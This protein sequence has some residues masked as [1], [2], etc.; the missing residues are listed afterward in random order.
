MSS[1]TLYLA[2]MD[3]EAGGLQGP[4]QEMAGVDRLIRNISKSQMFNIFFSLP[5]SQCPGDGCSSSKLEWVAGVCLSFLV[6]HSS[7]SE[8]APVVLWGPADHHSSILASEA[9]VSG[10]SRSG[11]RRSG[12]SSTVQGSSATAPLPSGSVQAV[13]S[14]LETIKRFTRASGFSKHVAQQVSLARCPS[15]RAGYQS[16]WLVYRQWCRSEGH[17][18]SRP[19]LAKIADFLFWLRRSRQLSVSAVMGYRS[20]LSAVFKSI[21]PEISSS[22]TIHDL[23]RSFQVEAPVRE[24]HPPAWDLPTVLNY[25]R[26]SPFEPLSSASLRGLTRKTL[27]LLSLATAKRVGELQALSRRVSFSSSAGLSYVP[28]FV[29]KTESAIRPLPRSFEVKSLGDFAAG[30]PED[31][32]LCPVRSLSAY[33]TQT[34]GIVNRPCRLFISSKCPSR[35]MSKNGISYMLREVIV[36]SG[37]S[38]QSGQVPR[39]HSIRG[40]A[41]SSAFFRNWSLRSVLEAAFWRSNTIYVFLCAGFIFKFRWS[42]LFGT[43]RCCW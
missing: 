33:L 4:V 17:S 10:S 34:S 20:M 28:E 16:K 42:S 18:I 5:R 22:P 23:L 29:A 43:I 27:F 36:Q 41:T 35:A 7:S 21:L 25:L 13:A 26:S 15:S 24:V 30:L 37:A 38:S 31:L 39:A 32:L 3:A 12:C 2:R 8:E 11:G 6:T 9:V 19:S 1:R 14:C 40:I